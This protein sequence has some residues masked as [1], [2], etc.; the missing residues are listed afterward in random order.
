[1]SEA[2]CAVCAPLRSGAVLTR[3][4]PNLRGIVAPNLA[5]PLTTEESLYRN[6]ANHNGKVI[7][8]TA[9]DTVTASA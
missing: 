8:A 1:M 9:V 4:P 7:S 3:R 2:N 5:A 6:T